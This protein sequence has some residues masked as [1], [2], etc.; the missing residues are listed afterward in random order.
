M[1]QRLVLAMALVG[2]PDLLVLDEPT[3]GLDPNG[4]REMRQIIRTERD[5]GTTVFFSSHIL[6]QVEAICDRV[7]ILDRGRIVAV[8]TI[9]GLREAAGTEAALTITVDA[10]PE[11]SVEAV[12]ALQGVESV[13]ADGDVMTV[14]TDGGS[15]TD[16]LRALEDYG[17]EIRDF[18]TEETSLEELF[19]RYTENC[20]SVAPG[21]D[22]L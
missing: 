3:T 18:A 21:G 14:R 13:A 9:E 10:V 8:D 12:D 7:A 4:A 19:A 17:A 5:R 11:G 1:R 22:A 2:E 16:I 15:K 20:S 6:E